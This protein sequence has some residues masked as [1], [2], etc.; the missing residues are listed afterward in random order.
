MV[1]ARS[2]QE[3]RELQSFFLPDDVRLYIQVPHSPLGL[4]R[5]REELSSAEIRGMLELCARIIAALGGY[6]PREEVKVAY[7]LELSNELDYLYV[8]PL[9]RE[10]LERLR[11][12]R[13][14]SEVRLVYLD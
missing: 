4:V 1:V 6:A 11:L 12:P 5:F 2:P 14:N 13:L 8:R 7:R 10:Y 3:C 9:E